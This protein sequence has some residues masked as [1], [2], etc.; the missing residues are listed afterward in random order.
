MTRVNR[1]SRVPA[2]PAATVEFQQYWP[3]SNETIMEAEVE[4]WPDLVLADG[5][6]SLDSLI[7][8]WPR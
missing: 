4:E 1:G 2:A 3:S 7:L 5:R 6:Y 8:T